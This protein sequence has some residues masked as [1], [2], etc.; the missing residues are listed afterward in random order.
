MHKN[1]ILVVDDEAI[2]LQ[3]VVEIFTKEYNVKVAKNGEDALRLIRQHKPDLVLLDIMMP[4]MSGFEVAQEIK[5]DA[6]IVNTPFMFLTA[7]HDIQNIIKAFELGACDYISKPF[8]KEELLLR[9]HTH[10][11]LFSLQKELQNKV[12]EE[13]AKRE[14]KEKMLLTQSKLAAMGEMMDAVAHQWKQPISII[15]MQTE[16]MSFDLLDGPLD[17]AYV[18]DFQ[19]KINAQIDHMMNT[20]DEFRS[21]LRPNKTQEAF[22]A[23]EMI[24]KVLLLMK[25]ELVK[26]QI[27]VNVKAL[28][29]FN[30]Y[31]IENEIK[32]L[33]INIINNAKDAFVEK[34]IVGRV[35]E[36]ELD[37]DENEKRIDV[38]DNAGGIPDNIIGEIFKANFTTKE[39]GKGTGIGLYMS[40]QIAMKNNAILSV[41]NEEKGAKFR[42]AQKVF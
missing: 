15:K 19:E 39:E 31:G 1:T 38:I 21:F 3:V 16:V 5:K 17:E 6:A 8:V 22:D 9:V 18:Q 2:N 10:L 27:S 41:S 23:Q 28:K 42:F 40:M 37:A 25:D 35:I 20:L 12:A 4:H 26:N 14:E 7:M 36:I 29:E 30:L 11:E 24:N 13:I 33:F 34:E 32:H